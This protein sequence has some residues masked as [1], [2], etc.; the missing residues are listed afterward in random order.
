MS[1]APADPDWDGRTALLNRVIDPAAS[2]SAGDLAHYM[3]VV[4]GLDTG[5]RIEL[6]DT[7]LT[8]GRVP[9]ADIVFPDDE[10]SRRHCSIGVLM[11]QVIVTDLKATNGTFLDG[12]RIVGAAPVPV[13]ALVQVGRQLLKYERRS[14]KEVQA[15]EELNRDLDRASRYVESLLPPPITTGPITTDWIYLPSLRLGGDTF[16]YHAL[17]PQTFAVYLVDV[18]GHGPESAMH[19]V[20]IMNVLRQ[21][22]L[23]DTDFK[24]PADV[25]RRLNLMFPMEEHASMFFTI[26]YG[27]F[28]ASRRVIDFCS[29]GHHPSFLVAGETRD[30]VPLWQHNLA[31]GVMSDAEFTSGSAEVPPDAMLYV[32]SDGVFEIVTESGQRWEL[33]DFLKVLQA[34]PEPGTSEPARLHAAVRKAARPGGFDDDFSLLTVRFE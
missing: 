28:D 15:A 20:G 34:T 32:F 21:R 6:G 19:A 11:G 29:A 22:A 16:G 27:V 24:R 7:A 9:P 23:P 10:V 30:L 17:D 8:I 33:D 3:V 12:K 31:A 14:R 4:E 2:T 26:W 5:R 1:N 25:V 13:G 18:S